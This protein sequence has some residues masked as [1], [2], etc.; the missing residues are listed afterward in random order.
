MIRFGIARR[1]QYRS[2]PRGF[3]ERLHAL[4]TR[5]RISFQL[6][7][8][9][10]IPPS[11][12]DVQLFDRLMHLMRLSTGVKRSTYSGRFAE[13]DR[14]LNTLLAGRF[15]RDA[16]LNVHDWAA[17]D[18]ITSAEWAAALF[19]TFPNSRLIASDLT[20]YIVEIKAPGGE[21]FIT[22]RSGAP[23]QYVRRPFVIRL[24]PPE[25][26]ALL[27][28]YLLCRSAHRKL[29]RIGQQIGEASACLDGGAETVEIPPLA[30]SKISVVHPEA[31]ALQKRDPR[32]S[33]MRHSVFEPLREP[34]D[35]IRSMNIF[36]RS[37]FTPER[38]TEGIR[39]VAGSLKPSGI[40][41]VGRTLSKASLAHDISVFENQASGFRLLERY[42]AGSEIE[43]LVSA[44]SS[45]PDTS[46]IA[47][48]NSDT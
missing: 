18:C 17:S 9:T 10:A 24:N 11:P 41:V 6:L 2:E 5:H 48:H 7:R 31:T 15:P 21:C 47:P 45:E 30:F 16:A 33:V 34:A 1:E 36:N 22:E 12:E 23:L 14:S 46:R 32:F 3:F 43:D 25:P 42:G 38:L 13:V 35:V 26:K 39:A 20:L 29:E 28:N 27:V 37:Y 8:T 19:Q 4:L 40:W 44:T